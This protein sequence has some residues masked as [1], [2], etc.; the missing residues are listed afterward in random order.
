MT[1]KVET[2]EQKL[3]KMIE[4]STGP[5]AVAL[6]ADQ[7]VVNK[8][9]ALVFIKSINQFLIAG[10]FVAILFFANELRSGIATLNKN[11]QFSIQQKMS[12]QNLSVANLVPTVQSLAFYLSPVSQRNIFQ[13]IDTDKTKV[14]TQSTDSNSHIFQKTQ[15]LR[16]V[17]ISWLNNV[18]SASAMIEDTEKKTTYFLKKGDK[19]DDVIIKTIYADSAILGYEN[20]E[21]TIKYDK[22]QM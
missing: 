6:K 13:P 17:G 19:I 21:M 10:V 22:S 9:N 15:H 5:E 2:A 4:A 8:Q 20:E 18:D 1:K 11:F 16:L 12:K 14:A 7:K 3:L